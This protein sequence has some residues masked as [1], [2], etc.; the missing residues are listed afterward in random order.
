MMSYGKLLIAVVENVV[1]NDQNVKK[2]GKTGADVT[3]NG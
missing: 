1:I 3:G 2:S